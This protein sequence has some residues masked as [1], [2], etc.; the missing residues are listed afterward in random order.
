MAQ[1][2]K[3]FARQI[4]DSRGNPT[5]EVDVWA[6]KAKGRFGVPSGASTGSKEAVELRDGGSGFNGKAVSKAVTNV[7]KVLGPR[8]VG[9]DVS[10]QEGIDK[11]MIKLDGTKNKSKLGANA[12]LGCSIACAKAAAASKEVGIYEYLN[13]KSTKIPVPFMNVING[14]AHAGNNLEFQE[15]M[16]APVGAKNFA[17]AYQICSEIYS[18]LREEIVKRYGRSA[19]N[20]GDEGGYAPPIDD[21]DTALDLI[22]TAVSA[23]GHSKKV[24]MALDVAA[25]EFYNKPGYVIGEKTYSRGELIDY[26]KELEKSYPIVSIEDPFAESDWAGFVK[27]TKL[28]VLIFINM[29]L[30]ILPIRQG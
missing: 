21:T 3:V 5:V 6:E 26:Y 19:T 4:Y 23:S 10:D 27:I 20:I 29:F 13:P 25:T 30:M 17:E 1:I 2:T 24:R 22:E 7:N 9:M 14:G 12:I 18:S 28:F 15:H 11:L 8:L 16:I